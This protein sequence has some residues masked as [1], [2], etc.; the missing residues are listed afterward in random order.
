[1]GSFCIYRKIVQ[2]VAR[3]EGKNV[4]LHDSSEWGYDSVEGFC[5][6]SNDKGEKF[7]DQLCEYLASEEG[8]GVREVQIN[9][10]SAYLQ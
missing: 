5:E 4:R 8:L 6:Y 9:T 3:K 1:L 2:S 10:F 7:Y